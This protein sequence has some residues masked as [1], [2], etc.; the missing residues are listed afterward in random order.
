MDSRLACLWLAACRATLVVVCHE[1]ALLWGPADT[2]GGC[3]G[4]SAAAGCAVPK[5]PP[6]AAPAAVASIAPLPSIS[7]TAA[8]APAASMAS[9]KS[10]K[11]VSDRAPSER[12]CT[13]PSTWVM[14]KKRGLEED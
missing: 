4:R 13:S 1:A 10:D 5:L 11:L 14:R 6:A 12:C 7:S 3:P 2:S 9:M 8:A